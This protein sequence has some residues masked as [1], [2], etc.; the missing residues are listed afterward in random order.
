MGAVAGQTRRRRFATLLISAGAVWA[1]FAMLALPAGHAAAATTWATTAPLPAERSATT[2]TLLPNG[3]VLVAGGVDTLGVPQSSAYLYNPV[4]QSWTQT[5]SMRMARALDVAV[6]LPDGEVLAAGG[7][8]VA[9]PHAQTTTAT[10]EVF[11]PT[12]AKWTLVGSMNVPRSAFAA[13]LLN[14]GEVLVEGGENDATQ[15]C[16][17]PNLGSAELY[18]PATKVWTPTGSLHQTSAYQTATLLPGGDV[19]VAGGYRGEAFEG[20]P[21]HPS[22]PLAEAEVYTTSSGTW[23]LTGDLVIQRWLHTATLLA[24]GRVLVV[25][26][27]PANVLSGLT[28]TTQD[29]EI[30][31]PSTTDATTGQL[32]SWSPV[33]PMPSPRAEH[34]ATLLADGRVL[35]TG[36]EQTDAAAIASTLLY[37][38]ATETWSDG[39]SMLT[40][41]N[42]FSAV[43][44]SAQPC[45]SLCNDVLV[46]GGENGFSLVHNAN[47]ATAEVFTPPPPAP[48]TTVPSAGETG[49]SVPD[50]GLGNSWLLVAGAALIVTGLGS[51]FAK[52]LR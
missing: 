8:T 36:G 30:Y 23:R 3:E 45:G 17:C 26:G 34:T 12:T 21:S 5:G 48:G 51:R 7:E 35:I 50:T 47:T 29:A 2:S 13:T 16:I 19:L 14:S 10:A 33:P 52:T 42:S 9:A 37:D 39:G 15:V 24:D 25:G 28:P 22:D 38:P 4:T 32:G 44:L 1:A 27:Y 18:N 20:D 40:P 46:V 41:R 11:N 49:V 43:R 6:L 31:N